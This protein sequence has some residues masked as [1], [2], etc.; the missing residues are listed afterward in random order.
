MM[1]LFDCVDVECLVETWRFW[2]VYLDRRSIGLL[3]C[4]AG[5]D[6]NGRNAVEIMRPLGLGVCTALLC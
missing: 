6:F 1:L 4:K 5:F 3:C 2:T